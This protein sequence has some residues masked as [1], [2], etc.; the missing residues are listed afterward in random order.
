[1]SSTTGRVVE[2]TFGGQGRCAGGFAFW[3]SFNFWPYINAFLGLF[4]NFLEAS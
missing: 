2:E 1:M 3:V 4:L